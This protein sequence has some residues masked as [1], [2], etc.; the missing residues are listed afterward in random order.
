M[1]EEYPVLDEETLQ[2]TII[3]TF[4]EILESIS[5]KFQTNPLAAALI[6]NIV[7]SMTS[8][9][10]LMLQISLGLFVREKKII[11]CLQELGVTS[12][13]DE[14]RRF[15]ISA[16]HHASK[17]HLI[18][19][20]E[21]GLIQ[22]LSDKFDANLSTQN[23]LKQTH[24]LAIVLLQCGNLTHAA[25]SRSPIPRLLKEDLSSV[26]LHESKMQIFKGEKKPKMPPAFSKKGILPFKVLCNQA[27]LVSRSKYLDFQFVKDMVIQTSV[28]DFA[29][30]NT[31]QMRESGQSTK[32]KTKVIYKP[33]I[34]KTPSDPSTILTAMCDIETTGKKSGQRET[35]FTC[36]QQL[37]RVTL[38][39]IWNDPSR[40]TYFYP[41]IG[42]MHWLMSFVG[43]VGKLTKNSGLDMLM[44]TAFAGV[45]MMLTGKKFPMNIRAVRIVVVELLRTLIDKD[46]RQEDMI[47]TFQTLSDTSQLAKYWIK[48]VIYPVF[49]MM[50]YIRAER[51]GEFG[52]HLYGCKMIP[53]FFATGYWNYA[54]DSIIYLRSIEKM[55]SNLLNRFMNG[56]HVIRTKDGLFNG[57]WSDIAIETTYMKVGKGKLIINFDLLM[58]CL[59]HVKS[60]V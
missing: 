27:I 12:S 44:K 54:R 31:K 22:G 55:P 50:M 6:S 28:P 14:V 15:N 30:Y 60:I 10:V 42:G 35:V 41:R 46:A 34:N 20:S 53:Y 1:K 17:D 37:Y 21:K 5:P 13:Y 32:Q 11:E 45:E 51:E 47:S 38:D 57:I 43:S 16:V 52:L 19:D 25:D 39:T 59:C 3:P 4:N 58:I 8:S 48:N 7:T 9:K 40:W 2:N 33:L 18:L 49:L 56:E 36:D 23:G 26:E 24:S 29:A